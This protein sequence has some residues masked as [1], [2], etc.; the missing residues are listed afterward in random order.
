MMTKKYLMAILAVFVGM[1]I[2]EFLINEVGLR[3][4]Y[5]ETAFLWRPESDIRAL[6]W[7]MFVSYAVFALVFVTIFKRGYEEN[8]PGL[9]Q[10]IRYGLL[11]GLLVSAPMALGCYVVMPIPVML[12]VAWFVG[13]MAE[14]IVLGALAGWVWKK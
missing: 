10:G 5:A 13:G 6:S 1:G 9:G 14:M 2:I 11:I 12:A 3:G 7:L 4:L 8:K